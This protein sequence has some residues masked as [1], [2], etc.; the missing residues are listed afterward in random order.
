[1]Q[2]RTRLRIFATLVGLWVLAAGVR[3]PGLACNP[4]SEKSDCGPCCRR[5]APA[6]HAQLL[7]PLM[8]CCVGQEPGQKPSVPAIP[9]V[10]PWDTLDLPPM[11]PVLLAAERTDL[12][13]IA[14]A[15]TSRMAGPPL[16]IENSALLL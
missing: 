2:R 12:E 8:A 5:A 3:A 9:S 15:L 6:S 10:A 7:R 14:A 13:P 4:A 1:M 16:W 11:G